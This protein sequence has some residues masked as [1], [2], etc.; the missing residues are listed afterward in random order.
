MLLESQ[1]WALIATL[2]VFSSNKFE[3]FSKLP[4]AVYW[5]GGVSLLF[6]LGPS[7]NLNHLE[8]IVSLPTSWL[9][10]QPGFSSLGFPI[11]LSHPLVLSIALMAGTVTH[12]LF[13][14]SNWSLILLFFVLLEVQ[15]QNPQSVPS[16]SIQAPKIDSVEGK[17]I[18][19][20]HPI[21]DDIGW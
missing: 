21:V 4:T 12:H 18:F 8:P 15:Y 10:Q 14:R 17:A 1:L 13:R 9:Y 7:L 2:F 6:A 11:R 5:M 16:W 20:L 3:R 19:T